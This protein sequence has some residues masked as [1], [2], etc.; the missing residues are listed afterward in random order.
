M[1]NQ[2]ITQTY[3]DS[4]LLIY[5]ISHKMSCAFY[6]P[7]EDV[8]GQAHLIFMEAFRSFDPSYN[9]KFTTWLQIRLWGR[10]INWL[11]KEYPEN[12]HLELDDDILCFASEADRFRI[13]DMMKGL[14]GEARMIVR[15]VCST[16]K[17]LQDI[18]T[19]TKVEGKR[20]IRLTIHEYLV[21][22]FGWA[23]NEVLSSFKEIRLALGDS[24]PSEPER[25]DKARELCGL[26][27]GRVWFLTRKYR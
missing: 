27:R 2:G 11:K 24:A 3:E 7:F 22:R 20:D 13:Q 17:E 9:A 23:T 4:R 18:I 15:L 6:V 19:I 14:S 8:L 5:Q 1:T 10:L 12:L 25:P 16:P 21:D 26:S